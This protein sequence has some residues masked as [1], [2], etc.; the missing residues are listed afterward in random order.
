MSNEIENTNKLVTTLVNASE[1]LSW[2]GILK[3]LILLIFTAVII[4]GVFYIILKYFKKQPNRNEPLLQ[5]PNILSIIEKMEENQ[6]E[7]IYRI[8]GYIS[9]E[10]LEIIIKRYV[11]GYVYFCRM[12]D[13]IDKIKTYFDYMVNDISH[14]V[15]DKRIFKSTINESKIINDVVS[16]VE[17]DNYSDYDLQKI[18]EESINNAVG[19]AIKSSKKLSYVEV[20]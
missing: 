2:S 11:T 13:H 5:L 16:M 20:N 9:Q 8:M 15:V 4:L 12:E 6:K 17:N 14:E 18:I 7:T 19:A 3:F 10:R 1:T